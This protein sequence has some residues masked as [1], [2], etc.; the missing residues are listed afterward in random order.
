MKNAFRTAQDPSCLSTRIFSGVRLWQ[1]SKEKC[2]RK[3]VLPSEKELEENSRSKS[4]E[5]QG[6][7][8]IS[9]IVPAHKFL[10]IG[11]SQFVE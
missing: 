8:H 5:A 4:A 3:P 10:R 2:L 7:E 11:D 9:R 6:I 1:K